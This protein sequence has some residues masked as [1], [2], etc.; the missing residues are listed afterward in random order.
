MILANFMRVR[1]LGK[2]DLRQPLRYLMHG[3][4]GCGGAGG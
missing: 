4:D 1:L 3:T 2:K